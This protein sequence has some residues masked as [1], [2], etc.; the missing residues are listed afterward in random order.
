MFIHFNL[1][2]FAKPY[3][4]DSVITVIL[5]TWKLNC[6]EVKQLAPDHIARK[7]SEPSFKPRESILL[8]TVILVSWPLFFS[9]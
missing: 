2:I 4:V 6:R 5:H 3:L 7:L 1:L 8:T 9:F